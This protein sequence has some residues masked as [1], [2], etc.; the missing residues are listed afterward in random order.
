MICSDCTGSQKN[1]SKIA[2]DGN[3]DAS[4]M[5]DTLCLNMATCTIVKLS[6]TST[7]TVYILQ[8]LQDVNGQAIY[9]DGALYLGH[10]GLALGMQANVTTGTKWWIKTGGEISNTRFCTLQS[11]TPQDS[12]ESFLSNNGSVLR[13]VSTD[14]TAYEKWTIAGLC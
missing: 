1:T 10:N 8:A 7:T 9:G 3:A 14:D 6:T 5:A 12:G 4:N 11:V 13:M 2:V